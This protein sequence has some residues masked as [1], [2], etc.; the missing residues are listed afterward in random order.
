MLRQHFHGQAAELVAAAKQSAV[1]L[2]QLVAA[3]L[4][5]FRDHAIHKGR[6]V[7]S[8]RCDPIEQ[9]AGAA[10]LSSRCVRHNLCLEGRCGHVW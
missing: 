5:G 9:S 1:S 4:P 10:E 6:Q 7:G 8:G 3:H 2:V